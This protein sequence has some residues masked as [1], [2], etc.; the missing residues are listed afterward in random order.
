MAGGR[1]AMPAI[2]W[3][4]KW[5]DKRPEKTPADN[6]ADLLD[7]LGTARRLY[8][9]AGAD[10]PFG[11]WQALHPE[12][13]QAVTAA[14][15]NRLGASFGSSMMERA[16]IDAAGRLTGLPFDRM[17][18]EGHLDLRPADVLPEATPEDLQAAL[19]ERPLDRIAPAPHGR[20]GR[21]RSPRPT[22]IP[23]IRST[24]AS[25]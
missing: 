8:G 10:T 21:P 5:F 20:A 25:R 22:W 3:P 19:P 9:E 17:L 7:S 24:T 11:L 15:F 4:N 13:E 12:I 14:G 18:R 1:P 23:T 6:V 16:V 2:S